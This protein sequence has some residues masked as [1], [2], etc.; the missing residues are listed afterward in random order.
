MIFLL[1]SIEV[2]IDNKRR[3]FNTFRFLHLLKT[4][5]FTFGDKLSN[6]LLCALSCVQNYRIKKGIMY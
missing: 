1:K 6:E 5:Y 4:L 2:E 3:F